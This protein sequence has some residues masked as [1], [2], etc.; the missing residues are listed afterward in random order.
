MR[1]CSLCAS[2]GLLVLLMAGWSS[3]A[4]A[5]TVVGQVQL[6]NAALGNG[7]SGAGYAQDHVY[8]CGSGFGG[9]VWKV[10][11]G[12]SNGP[13]DSTPPSEVNAVPLSGPC[14]DGTVSWDCVWCL[15][16][17]IHTRVKLF[18]SQHASHRCVHFYPTHKCHAQVGANTVGYWLLATTPFTIAKTNGNAGSAAMVRTST[19]ARIPAIGH[20]K[21]H[22]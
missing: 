21:L 15:D 1:V 7:P 3:R 8:Y 16:V 2:T 10:A 20:Y 19:T 12:N 5:Q 22:T 4:A 13:S 9:G 17:G 18:L 14:Q 11:T 6:T